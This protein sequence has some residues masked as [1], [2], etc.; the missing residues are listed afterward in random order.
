M[1]GNV[2]GIANKTN[3][4][5]WYGKVGERNYLEDLGVDGRINLKKM[6]KQ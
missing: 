2:A 1:G 6:L 3:Q 5:L 4:L